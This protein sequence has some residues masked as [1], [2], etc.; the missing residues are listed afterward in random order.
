MI[1]SNKRKVSL[2]ESELLR[3]GWTEKSQW[4]SENAVSNQKLECKGTWGRAT[5]QAW[6]M[7]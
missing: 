1:Y 2:P 3:G 6:G 5:C 7:R 4:F